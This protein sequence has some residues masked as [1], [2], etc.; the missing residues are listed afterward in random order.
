MNLHLTKKTKLIGLFV[1]IHLS[2]FAQNQTMT[3]NSDASET[4]FSFS[5]WGWDS[6]IAGIYMTDPSNY[7]SKI[8]KTSGVWNFISFDVTKIY[9]AYGDH[10]TI[11]VQSD[12]GDE[13]TFFTST[14]GTHTLNWNGIK[15]ITFT[16]ID[17]TTGA[18]GYDN[19]VYKPISPPTVTTTAAQNILSSSATLGG[20]ATADGGET[21]DDKGVVYSRS[22][23]NTNPQVGGTGVTKVTMGSGTGS[24]SQSVTSLIPGATYYFNAY[25]HNTAGYSYGTVSS[26][27]TPGPEMD[28]SGNSISIADGSTTP[29][30]TNDT[31]FGSEDV[32]SGSATHT[33][34]ISNTGNVT[35]NLTGTPDIVAISGDTGDFSITQPSGSSV[36]SG[37]GTVT[38]T[39]TFD[40]T[41]IGDKTAVISIANDDS[42]ENP[43]TFTITGFGTSQDIN[44]QG[45]GNDIADGNAVPS[46]ADDTDFGSVLVVSGTIVKTFTIQN[47]GTATLS[48]TD[49]S[50]YV[51]IGGSHSG[52]F[53]VTA[54]PSSSIAV[55][56][57]TTFEI[58]FDPTDFGTR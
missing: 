38:F 54:I 58:T 15:W 50:P 26:F 1:I 42:D 51:V 17:G 12:K 16:K 57:S 14:L 27:A 28:V 5:R 21:I 56:G 7:S 6:E 11:K 46:T 41:T 30:A 2:V 40:P 44:V 24:F 43:Y 8:T 49:P 45:N 48:L 31:D 53:S 35:L 22:T 34:T 19:F 33:F 55:S 18:G 47:T 9:Y 32:S 10:W 39:V 37:G 52:D 23:V 3:F 36:A 4:G 29:S 25:A 20:N 13:Y